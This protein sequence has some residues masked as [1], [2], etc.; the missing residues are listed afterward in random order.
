MIIITIMTA[1]SSCIGVAA[2]A[3]TVPGAEATLD[4]AAT[5]LPADHGVEVAAEGAAEVAME[6]VTEAVMEAA[7]DAAVVV[8]EQIFTVDYRRFS[9][10]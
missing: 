9:Q 1:S 5:S 7:V 3:A 2:G 6:V 10:R 4:G 8:V